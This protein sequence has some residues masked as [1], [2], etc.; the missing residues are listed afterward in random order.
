[1]WQWVE[2]AGLWQPFH[3][4]FQN[5][6]WDSVTILLEIRTRWHKTGTSGRFSRTD[7]LQIPLLVS[8]ASKLFSRCLSLGVECFLDASSLC[9]SGANASTMEIHI[10]SLTNIRKCWPDDGLQYV[11]WVP[12]KLMPPLGSYNEEI[13]SIR[14]IHVVFFSGS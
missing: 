11:D 6:Y 12:W 8:L 7:Q 2:R 5:T 1:M 10:S 13:Q 4:G 14:S 3:A 9:L